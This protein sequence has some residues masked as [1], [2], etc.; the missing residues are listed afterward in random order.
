M[1]NIKLLLSACVMMLLVSVSCENSTKET[2]T[3]TITPDLTYW[4]LQGPVKHCNN[5]EFDRQGTMVSIGDYNPFAIDQAYRD[6]DGD[7]GFVEYAKWERDEEG[8]V[9]SITGVEGMSE[10]TWSDGRVVSASGF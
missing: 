5:V 9:A 7:E 8:R 10:L 3:V 2:A 6:L 4:D 1:K